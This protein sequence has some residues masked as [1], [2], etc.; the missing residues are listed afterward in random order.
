MPPHGGPTINA[1]EVVTDFGRTIKAKNPIN[2]L[3]AYLFEC[4]FLLEHNKAFEITLENLVDWGIVQFRLYPEEKY[5]A[6][7]GGKKP[8]VIPCQGPSLTKKTLVI[9]WGELAEVTRRAP[10]KTLLI[11]TTPKATMVIK[12][13]SPIPYENDKAVPWSYNSV[14]YINGVKQESGP[15]ATQG[16]TISNIA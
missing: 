5:I 9:P 3:K 13:L 8:L 7:I 12:G 11:P 2:L 4:G 6:T 14:V 15:S 10:K 16:P 1:I